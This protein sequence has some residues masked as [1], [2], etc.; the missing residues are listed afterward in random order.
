MAIERILIVDKDEANHLF[1]EVILREMGFTYTFTS[2]N[3][4]GGIEKAEKEQVQMVIAAWELD[5]T[6][7]GT[8]F[9]QKV[10]SK[11]RRKYMPCLIYSKRMTESDV[12]LTRELGYEDVLGMPFNKEAAKKKLQEIIDRE[13]NISHQ[14]TVLRRIESLL[15]EDNTEEALKLITPELLQNKLNIARTVTVA[16]ETYLNAGN[17]AMVDQMLGRAF[18]ADPNYYPAQ[19]LKARFL[20]QQGKKLEA[21]A[22]LK[23]MAGKCPANLQTKLNLGNTYIGARQY[24]A[25]KATFAE[26]QKLDSDR[27]DAKD[28]L[29]T[30]A[31]AEGNIPLAVQLLAETENG[32]DIAKMLNAIAITQVNGKEFDKGIKTYR[33]AIKLLQNKISAAKLRFNLA[34]AFK[35][36]GDLLTCWHELA[37]CYVAEPTFEKAY[38]MLVKITQ[39]LKTRNIKPPIETVKKVKTAREQNKA[40]A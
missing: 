21:I 10:K 15:A 2:R 27:Q 14:E 11:R 32:Y 23:E 26:V 16:A 5:S 25:A 17:S 29:A 33:E 28:G 12:Q 1:F 13:N 6:M 3:G 36:K 40:A 24:E 39:E 30:V 4:V 20:A 9:V 18:T 31:V 8:V 22:L 34:L 35:K 7:S 38:A 19:Q 37:D